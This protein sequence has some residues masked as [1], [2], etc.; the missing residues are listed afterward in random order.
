[1]RSLQ[2]AANARGRTQIA[3]LETFVFRMGCD[4]DLDWALN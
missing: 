3:T 1:M 4:A 2:D